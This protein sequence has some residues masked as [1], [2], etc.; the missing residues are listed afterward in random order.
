M[1]EGKHIAVM[2]SKEWYVGAP[3]YILRSDLEELGQDGEYRLVPCRVELQSPSHD[4]PRSW[5]MV[6]MKGLT[7]RSMTFLWKRLHELLPTRERQ[8]R[9]LP[10]GDGS[11]CQICRKG[12]ADTLSHALALCDGSKHVFEWL[13]TGIERFS[14]ETSV[15]KVLKLDVALS[16]PL[17]FN[18]LPIIWFISEVLR[19]LWETRAAGKPCRLQHIRASVIA[20]CEMVRLSK[21]GDIATIIDIMI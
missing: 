19:N 20:E 1:G 8:N 14:S 15:D 11:N 21:Y 6:R 3:E 10:N 17:P 13:K 5:V 2:T 7:S 9:I 4:W 12:E 18:E 16:Q